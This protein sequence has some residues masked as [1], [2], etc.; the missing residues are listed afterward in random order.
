MQTKLKISYIN[1]EMAKF[2][3]ETFHYSKSIPGGKLVK[4]GVW[5]NDK[6]IGAVLFG[7]GVCPQIGNKYKL[8]QTQIC[9]LVRVALTKHETP[10]TKIISICLKILKK[11]FPSLKIIVSYADK[12]QGHEGV[13][14]RAGNWYLEGIS[15]ENKKGNSYIINGEK[16]HSRTLHKKYGVNSLKI[17][18]LRENIDPKADLW[19][20]KGKYKF[21]YFFDEKLKSDIIKNKVVV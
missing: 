7:S 10:V 13:I 5:E 2:S 21:L 1:H 14:Y 11:D 20:N 17:N 16:I 15:N 4:F 18:W 6:F 3:C 19:L 12:D 9:E 8:N